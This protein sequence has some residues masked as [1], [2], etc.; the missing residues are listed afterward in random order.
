MYII[1]GITLSPP[2]PP[3]PPSSPPSPPPS[4]SDYLQSKNLYS[5]FDIENH[6]SGT[7]LND[8]AINMEWKA[9]SSQKP[10]F[11]TVDGK[12]CL[13]LDSTNFVEITTPSNYPPLGQY[14]TQFYIW[15]PRTTDSGWR[16]FIEEMKIT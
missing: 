10:S 11:A 8:R 15:R 4:L 12:M 1:E 7:F 16:T 9:S 6:A 14:Y 3:S 2:H 13:N 5:H